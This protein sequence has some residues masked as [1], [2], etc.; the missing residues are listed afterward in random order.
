MANTPFMN[1]CE[2]NNWFDPCP[3]ARPQFITDEERN[4]QPKLQREKQKQSAG[5]QAA[6]A[7]GERLRARVGGNFRIDARTQTRLVLQKAGVLDQFKTSWNQVSDLVV[8]N[9]PPTWPEGPYNSLEQTIRAAQL[10]AFC[11]KN[12]HL[13]IPYTPQEAQRVAEQ[14]VA[15]LEAQLG[16]VVYRVWQDTR[17]DQTLLRGA[18]LALSCAAAG[19]LIGAAIGSAFYGVGAVPGAVCGAAIGA[20]VCFCISPIIDAVNV[21]NFKN[22]LRMQYDR[23]HPG[24]KYMMLR[25]AGRARHATAEYGDQ[26]A[27][28][29]E[30]IDGW[31]MRT[32][33][34]VEFGIP[35]HHITFEAAVN[36]VLLSGADIQVEDPARRE[37]VDNY[38][39]CA[40]TS[41]LA[42]DQKPDGDGSR[43]NNFF[44]KLMVEN[45]FSE[46]RKRFFMSFFHTRAGDIRDRA[47]NLYGITGWETQPLPLETGE[48]LATLYQQ[49]AEAQS[50]GV[51]RMEGGR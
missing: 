4:I 35:P 50:R 46:A 7:A 31:Q 6:V 44:G 10:D 12:Y 41:N 34:L 9:A 20:V 2:C 17:I 32:G 29:F 22:R 49:L 40:V 45:H 15:S 25:Y 24:E 39:L 23:L 19:A 5:Y 38:L 30:T 51:S 14:K 1:V 16:Q 21:D 26:N 27:A 3:T 8:A 43:A 48:Q 36:Q 37:L 28:R 42:R 47:A 18:I 13:C 11:K 33:D